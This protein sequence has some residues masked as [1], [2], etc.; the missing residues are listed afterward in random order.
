VSPAPGL[1][2]CCRFS[3][4]H[5]PDRADVSWRTALALF[6]DIGSPEAEEFRNLLDPAAT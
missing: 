3:T 5:R 1:A 4:D 6:T 2:P